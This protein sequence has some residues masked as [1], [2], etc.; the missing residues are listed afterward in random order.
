ME[1]FADIILLSPNRVWRTY[2]G[3]R[4]LDIADGKSHPKDSH[5]PED[6]IA[7]TTKATNQGRED[8]FEEGI[9]MVSINGK[10]HL[11]TNLL[12]AFANEL[13]GPDHYKKYG[14]RTQVLVKLLDSSI[15]L[16]IQVHPTV[17]FSRKYLDSNHGKTEAY[18]ILDVREE[19]KDPY[20]YFGFQN[21]IA[22][23]DFKKA[24]EKQDI[25][26]ITSCFEKVNIAPGDVFI[27]P[28][29]IPHAIGPGV[30]MIEIMEPTDFVARLEFERGGYLLP[31][32]ARF[33]DRGIDFA[34][35]MI[36]FKKISVETIRS[37]YFCKPR[38]LEEQDGGFEVVLID[39]KQ[40]PCFKVTRL[41][42]SKKYSTRYDSF[43]IAI[44][45]EGHGRVKT[46]T[47]EIKIKKGDR[48]LIPFSTEIVDYLAE[49]EL[50][51]VL[52]FPPK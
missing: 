25:K 32:A 41:H 30:L 52:A 44:V 18:V 36:H 29:G 20:I 24:V 34:M 45:T 27:V 10:N 46:A 16:H 31:E 3:G 35:D 23:E 14:S 13:V 43:Y 11:L 48:F 8:F 1:K 2:L 42:I 4:M 17:S 19:V 12:E 7:S 15:R 37:D 21:P 28:G 22:K 49:S 50:Q 47:Q 33:M 6:W 39:E 51:V 40:T 5:F 38:V 9:S 26:T